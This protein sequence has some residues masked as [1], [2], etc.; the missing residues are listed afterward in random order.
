MSMREKSLI[1]ER[2]TLCKLLVIRMLFFFFFIALYLEAGL[3]TRMNCAC[4][5]WSGLVRETVCGA[6]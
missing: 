6:V 2:R 5:V 3:H 1:Q 4:V